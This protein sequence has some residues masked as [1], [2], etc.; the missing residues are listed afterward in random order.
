MKYYRPAWCLQQRTT[1]K[2]YLDE[3]LVH[4]SQLEEEARIIVQRRKKKK[5]SEV[6]LPGLISETGQELRLR[7]N[8]QKK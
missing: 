5:K 8:M 1:S 4:Q 7:E 2:N 6:E 3:I